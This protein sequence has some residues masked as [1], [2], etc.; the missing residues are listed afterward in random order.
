M[1]FSPLE[2]SWSIAFSWAPSSLS[3]SS[4]HPLRICVRTPSEYRIKPMK[5]G[6]KNT[7]KCNRGTRRCAPLGSFEHLFCLSPHFPVVFKA[8]SFSKAGR[9]EVKRHTVT[10]RLGR[11]VRFLCR[12][13]F[14]LP[15]SASLLIFPLTLQRNAS[16]ASRRRSLARSLLLLCCVVCIRLVCPFHTF[17][18]FRPSDRLLF[19]FQL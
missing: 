10:E 3:L 13:L 14:Y 2:R 4:S 12:L 15:F 5:R 9:R 18:F 7:K 8:L 19:H 17:H 6:L 11:Y 1:Y 16:C